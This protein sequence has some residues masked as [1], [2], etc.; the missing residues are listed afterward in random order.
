MRYNT[1]LPS[2]APVERLFF[3]ATMTSVLKSSKLS[4]KMFEMKVVLKGNYSKFYV[5]E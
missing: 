5:N 3:Y 1:P 2:S 4:D